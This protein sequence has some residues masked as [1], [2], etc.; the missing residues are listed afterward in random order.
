MQ[1]E[2][3]LDRW[4]QALGGQERLRQ[5]EVVYTRMA[6]EMGGLTGTVEEWNTAQGQHRQSLDLG[7][8]Y[9]ALTV[10]DGERGWVLD[11]NGKVRDLAGIELEEEV[12]SAY[13]GSFS[14]LVP[15]RRPGRAELVS[16]DEAHAVLRLVPEGGRPVTCY[17]DQR[18]GLPVRQEQPAAERTRTVYLDDWR[19]VE[20]IPWPFHARQTTGDTR[21]DTV[22]RVEEVRFNGPLEAGTFARPAEAAPDFHFAAGR[23]AL[24]IPLELTSNHIYVQLRVNDCPPLWFLLDSGAGASV[25]DAAQ[26]QA[27]GLELQ[28]KLEGR[29]AGEGSTDVAFVTGATFRLPGVEVSDQTIAAIALAPLLPFEGRPAH[30]IL[31]YDF[32]SRFVVEVDYAARQIHL[33][34]PAAYT[35]TG[36]GERLP[37]ILE[38]NVPFVRGLLVAPDREP[39]A[40]KLLIDTGARMALDLSRPFVEAHQLEPARTIVAPFG[41]GVGGETRQRVGRMA[42]LQLAGTTLR[43]VVTGFS[44]D[45]KGAGA[46]PDSAGLIGG[47]VWR[48][49]KLVLDYAHQCIYL[50]ANAHAAEPFEYDMSGLF[51]RAEG[52][53]FDQFKVHRVVADS[54]AAEAGLREGD[55]IVALDGRPAAGFSLE[56]VRQLFKEEGREVHLDVQ[57]EGEALP[58]GLKLRRLI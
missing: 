52:A 20:G 48:R 51:L 1:V 37:I 17:L 25:I 18:T 56:Q 53:A 28:G 30:G 11:Q 15:G 40:A 54:P 33:Y 9:R 10:F 41:M 4:R 47:D 36:P 38:G 50:E 2:S 35:Y 16:A 49:F 46:D 5:V 14:H 8:V 29:G 27:L 43:D 39:V 55:S 3:F 7:G 13:L 21:Y 6:I 58:V 26:A 45:V 24:G 44:Q 31:G 19:E 42:G 57:R 23:S 34:D 32:I 22:L 12:T